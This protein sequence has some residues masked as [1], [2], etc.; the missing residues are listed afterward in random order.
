MNHHV[1]W[2]TSA[3]ELERTWNFRA[4]LEMQIPQF[5]YSRSILFFQKSEQNKQYL[6]SPVRHSLPESIYTNWYYWFLFERAFRI[7]ALESFSVV[8]EALGLV[9]NLWDVVV[10]NEVSLDTNNFHWCKI[11]VWCKKSNFCKNCFYLC[12]TWTALEN[13]TLL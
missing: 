10:S 3:Q 11:I 13:L 5:W 4:S 12:D 7:Q 9:F 2:S 6:T 8:R 1:S